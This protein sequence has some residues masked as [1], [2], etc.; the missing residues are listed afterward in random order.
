MIGLTE[1]RFNIFWKFP[2]F[3]K[4]F[5]RKREIEQKKQ[6]CEPIS[7]IEFC[8]FFHMGS[9]HIW[10]RLLLWK[11][12][13][14]I[15]LCI[16]FL[17]FASTFRINET[18]TRN[19]TDSNLYRSI[20]MDNFIT[21]IRCN[22]IAFIMWHLSLAQI[23]FSIWFDCFEHIDRNG[24][25]IVNNLFCGIA[26]NPIISTNKCYFLLGVLLAQYRFYSN[27]TNISCEYHDC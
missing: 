21:S 4:L 13:A 11:L 27:E 18:D 25:G 16:C 9:P 3:P 24:N 17:F 8:R 22:F 1:H 6:F 7:F 10:S 23:I 14:R 12:H 20:A 26:S 19:I 2:L 15:Y 5:R